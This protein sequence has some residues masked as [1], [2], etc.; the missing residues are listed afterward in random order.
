MENLVQVFANSEFGKL[1]TII[2]GVTVLF[3]AGDAA[4]MLGYARPNDAVNAHCRYTVKRSIP[5]PQG[6]GTLEVNVISEGDL[7]AK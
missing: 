5:H 1:R 4:K 2:E 6:K 3:V 7:S